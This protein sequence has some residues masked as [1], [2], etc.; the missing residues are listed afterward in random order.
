[1][2]VA[3]ILAVVLTE[4]AAELLTESRV[5]DCLRRLPGLL[6]YFFGCGYCA[7]VWI[8]VGSA[9]LLG[10]EGVLT[11]LGAAEPALW[12]LA[13]HRAS[14]VLHEAISRFMGRVPW[15]LFLNVSGGHHHRIEGGL[16]V[17]VQLPAEGEPTKPQAPAADEDTDVIDVE[18]AKDAAGLS[19]APDEGIPVIDADDPAN[20]LQSGGDVEGAGGGAD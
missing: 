10:L 20:R 17:D 19:P 13:V 8:G 11:G 12:G 14:N 7:S 2:I 1:M 16:P 3:F 9:Y 6:G 18:A 5:T 4:A 15:A